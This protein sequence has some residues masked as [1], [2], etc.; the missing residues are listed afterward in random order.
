MKHCKSERAAIQENIRQRPIHDSFIP[1]R[2]R[3]ELKEDGRKEAESNSAKFVDHLGDAGVLR[4]PETGI[5]QSP[6][7]QT[8][9]KGK[10]QAM[11]LALWILRPNNNADEELSERYEE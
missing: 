2:C 5:R 8:R 6:K 4:H 11:G 7:D 10:K 1:G 9:N 3:N